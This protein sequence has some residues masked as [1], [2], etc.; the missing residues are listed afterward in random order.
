MNQ[1]L[2]T[3]PKKL[4]VVLLFLLCAGLSSLSAQRTIT[5][6]VSDAAGP[7]PGASVIVKGT[8]TGAVADGDGNFSFATKGDNLTL[9][10]SAVGYSTKEIA[11]GAQTSI[12]VTLTEDVSTLGEVVVTGYFDTCLC[13]KCDFLRGITHSRDD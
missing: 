7:V 1:R 11:L 5:G 13:A 9:V 3:L 10:V 8:T 4:G 2:Y 6:N 12:K